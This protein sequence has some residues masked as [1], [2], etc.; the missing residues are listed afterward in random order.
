MIAAKSMTSS[1]RPTT[2]PMM[3]SCAFAQ[4]R[5]ESSLGITGPDKQHDQIDQRADK[6]DTGNQ[7]ATD[8]A[9]DGNGLLGLLRDIDMLL[10]GGRASSG[11]HLSGHAGGI[12]ASVAVGC[13]VFQGCSAILQ[14]IIVTSSLSVLFFRFLWKKPPSLYDRE[15]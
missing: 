2:M 6:G 7:A 4:L 3:I 5:K 13:I 12:A 1:V 9:A 11:L 14:S 15:E 10:N 8:P